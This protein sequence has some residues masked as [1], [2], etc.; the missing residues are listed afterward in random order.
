MSPERWQQINQLFYDALARTPP[1]RAD[2]LAQA[3]GADEE[4]RREV[5]TLLVADAKPEALLE[6]PL[7]AVA[8]EL[9]SDLPSTAPPPAA[10]SGTQLGIYQI[11]HEL[12]RG[13][14]GEVYLAQDQKLS[15]RVAL[16]LLPTRF[17]HDP[18]R[19]HRFRQEARAASALNHP[20]IVTIFDIGEQD[21]RHFMAPEFVE[22]QTLRA[23]LKSA[24]LSATQALDIA[25]QVASALAAAHQAGIIHRDI[26]PE[27]LMLRPD[28]YVKVLDF[29]LAKLT[30][31]HSAN[32]GEDSRSEIETRASDLPASFETRTGM[33]LGTVDYMSPEQARGQ[34]VDARS[35]IFSLGVVLYEMLTGARPFAGKTRNHVL[36]AILDQE[37]PLLAQH[38]PAAPA[39]L[40]NI[41][42]QPLRKDRNDRSQ[43]AKELLAE[44][45]QLKDELAVEAQL[46]R[47][48]ASGK[49]RTEGEGAP[50]PAITTDAETERKTTGALSL[51]S[52][53]KQPKLRRVLLLVV[54]LVL[55]V[56]GGAGLIKWFGTDVHKQPFAREQITRFSVQGTLEGGVIS[57]DGKF[58]VYVINSG[59]RGGAFG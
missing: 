3:C 59:E 16:K 1:A 58:I 9:W 40:Q 33:V 36:V 28:G 7:D 8:A 51:L 6:Q 32:Q 54:A 47:V 48:R 50:A 43:S 45:K 13:G 34:R 15:R 17:T 56:A 55:L 31:P 26:K 25:I 27:N 4:L 57:P 35:D 41:V 29:G 38:W 42:S 30:E 24:R 46:E 53:L 52:E 22:G 18:E 20:N 2:F 37:P 39:A 21:G 19:L 14:I 23:A 11:I 44:L 5:L 49:L 12:G 10:L